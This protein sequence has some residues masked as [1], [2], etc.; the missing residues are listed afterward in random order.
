MNALRPGQIEPLPKSLPAFFH[1][2]YRVGVI[3]DGS[4]FFHSLCCILNYKNYNSLTDSEKRKLVA[5]FRCSLGTPYP[6]EKKNFC[7]VS[8]WANQSLITKTAEHIGM[9]IMFI[10]MQTKKMYCGVHGEET[11]DGI[12]G[13]KNLNEPTAVVLWVQNG[14]HFEPLVYLVDSKPCGFFVPSNP[15]HKQ[16]IED[17][18]EWYTSI[19]P[20]PPKR[21][22]EQ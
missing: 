14:T 1:P 13:K 10:N 16:F 11:I 22:K 3:G 7:T 15:L 21:V 8:T 19:C 20:L 12:L 17:L 9:N 5:N 4:C 18:V 2:Y 6:A